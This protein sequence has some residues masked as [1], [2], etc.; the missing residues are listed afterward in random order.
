MLA[1]QVRG[2]HGA[3]EKLRTVGVLASIGHGQDAGAGM[4]VLEVLVLE[5][6]AVDG[7][8]TTAVTRGEIA[9]LQHKLGNHA[10]KRAARTKTTEA[11]RTERNEANWEVDILLHTSPCSAGV[12][13]TCP[14]PSRPCTASEKKHKK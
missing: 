13:Q 9:A 5:L 3:D 1:V 7:F 14:C 8:P 10:V 4:L 6:V 2:G 12:C 11:L